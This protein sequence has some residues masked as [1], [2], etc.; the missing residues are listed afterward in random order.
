MCTSMP[1]A[2]KQIDATRPAQD[3]TDIA[4]NDWSATIE[5]MV[6]MLP[7][8]CAQTGVGGLLLD[9]ISLWAIAGHR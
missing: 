7:P 4:L 3:R 8:C 6:F 2:I 9:Q 1:S 5:E